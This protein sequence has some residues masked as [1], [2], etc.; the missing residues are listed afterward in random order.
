MLE[1][2]VTAHETNCREWQNRVEDNLDA[3]MVKSERYNNRIMFTLIG[4]LVM[5]VGYLMQTNPPWA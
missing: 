1:T 3:F 4:G 2:R 5:V